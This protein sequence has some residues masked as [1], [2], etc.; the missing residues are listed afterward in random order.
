MQLQ[1]LPVMG[2]RPIVY[3][4]GC[5][6]KLIIATSCACVCKSI[7]HT[8]EENPVTWPIIANYYKWRRKSYVEPEI[9]VAA[10]EGVTAGSYLWYWGLSKDILG[11]LT[12]GIVCGRNYGE[13]SS[14]NLPG[15]WFLFTPKRLFLSE[16]KVKTQSQW[17]DY[18]TH[19]SDMIDT[20]ID[21]KCYCVN[22]QLY[23]FLARK[24]LRNCAYFGASRLLMGDVMLVLYCFFIRLL[25]GLWQK[26]RPSCMIQ[27]YT[28]HIVY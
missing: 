9:A 26:V 22:R 21:T 18:R 24:W 8:Y 17:S 10:Y 16:G 3:I 11:V 2:L 14:K 5:L 28:F 27:K 4:V 25:Q 7:C 19:C 23:C 1:G 6:C 12:T 15:M 20:I 13:G